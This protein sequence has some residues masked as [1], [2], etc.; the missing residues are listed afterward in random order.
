MKH[1]II[2]NFIDKTPSKEANKTA[3]KNVILPVLAAK[4]IAFWKPKNHCRLPKNPFLVIK[5]CF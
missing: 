3:S 5:A 4:I 1:E 2:T